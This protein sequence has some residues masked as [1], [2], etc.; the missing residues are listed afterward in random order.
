M[1]RSFRTAGK[2]WLLTGLALAASA[3]MP[4]VAVL[5][6]LPSSTPLPATLT[7]TATFVWFP[8]TATH[9]PFPTPAAVDTPTPTLA[10]S[11]GELIFKD[12]FSSLKLWS[13]GRGPAGSTAITQ[14]ELTVAVSKPG[15]YLYS[16]RQGSSLTNF[17]AELT[18]SPSLCRGQDEYGLLLRV[19]STSAFYRFSL[20][21]DGQ[22]RLDRYLSGR[23]SSPQPW[24]ASGAIPPGAPSSSRL[25]VLANGKEMQ[26]YVNGE[27][28][29]TVNEPSIPSGGLGVF[30]R[31]AGDTP[32]TVNFSDLE[33]YKLAP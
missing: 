33:V 14:N 10:P 15:G 25:A 30:A 6:P 13:L 32:I 31:S 12:D 20:S 4:A 9:T 11:H 18:A 29:F 22:A 21:C 3:C 7:P 5:P 17:Y 27:F 26:F 1:H 19:A 2:I 28:L 24:T 23:A 16:L 8:P